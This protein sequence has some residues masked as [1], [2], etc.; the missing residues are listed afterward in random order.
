MGSLMSCRE[1]VVKSFRDFGRDDQTHSDVFDD[2]LALSELDV[3]PIANR[4]S[5]HDQSISSELQ[6]FILSVFNAIYLS[7]FLRF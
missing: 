5:V 6:P 4:R 1:S 2:A 7:R 3:V